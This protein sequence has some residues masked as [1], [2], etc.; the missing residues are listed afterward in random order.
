MGYVHTYIYTYTLLYGIRKKPVEFSGSCSIS[1]AASAVAGKKKSEVG[2]TGFV[3][4]RSNRPSS[5]CCCCCAKGVGKREKELYTSRRRGGRRRHCWIYIYIPGA[6]VYT[7]MRTCVCMCDFA[8]FKTCLYRLSSA[9]TT[10]TT[11][12]MRILTGFGRFAQYASS[13]I[14]LSLSFS[15][16]LFICLRAPRVYE[17]EVY[18]YI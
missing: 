11:T 16:Y 8:A 13:A 10:T 7:Y 12:L 4:P 2:R 3:F 14:A 5:R 1:A 17:R 6:T 15:I 18:I 9:S